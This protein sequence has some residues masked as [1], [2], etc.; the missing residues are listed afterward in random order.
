MKCSCKNWFDFVFILTQLVCQLFNDNIGFQFSE[1]YKNIV[2]KIN[3]RNLII[4][5]KIMA[6]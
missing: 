1:F 2:I 6:E 3:F 5:S 4:N